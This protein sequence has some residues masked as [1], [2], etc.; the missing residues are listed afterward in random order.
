MFHNTNIF[1]YVSRRVNY[2]KLNY[3]NFLQQDRPWPLQDILDII[4]AWDKCFKYKYFEFR[5]KIVEI[6]KSNWKLIPAKQLNE[7]SDVIKC[8]KHSLFLFTDDDDFYSPHLL[9]YVLDV[10]HLFDYDIIYW[11]TCEFLTSIIYPKE[12]LPD[13]PWFNF[14]HKR[15]LHSNNF[16][17]TKKGVLKLNE[18]DFVTS[19][20]IHNHMQKLNCYY[21]NSNL[22]VG[23]KTI[24]SISSLRNVN[25]ID[26][27]I[28]IHNSIKSVDIPEKI[29]WSNNFINQTIKLYHE[30]INRNYLF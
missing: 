24:S 27:I 30:N 28:K 1:T 26:D 7:W 25:N 2:E 15:T 4:K 3:D 21:I 29:K 22:N 14:K 23:N 18:K 19:Q 16:C 10:P 5:K 17:M 11:N 8:D 12:K 9:D 20:S 13:K 6:A